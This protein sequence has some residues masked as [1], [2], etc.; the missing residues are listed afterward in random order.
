L[1]FKC[2]LQRYIEVKASATSSKFSSVM[3]DGLRG[4]VRGKPL[5]ITI[6]VGLC[7]LESS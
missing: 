4:G 2:N 6:V 7:T 5:E 3:G 1:P